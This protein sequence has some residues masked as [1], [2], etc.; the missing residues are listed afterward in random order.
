MTVE[1][2]PPLWSSHES[3]WLQTKRSRV[4][5][6]RYRNF[7]KILG[8]ERGP[9]SLVRINEKLLGRKISGFGLKTRD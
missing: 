9:L 8:L 1:A 7:R 5:S 3:S 2:E 4:Q 6:R